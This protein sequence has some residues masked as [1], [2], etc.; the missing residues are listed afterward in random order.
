VLN[1]IAHIIGLNLR[2]FEFVLF[3]LFGTLYGVSLYCIFDKSSRDGAFLAVLSYFIIMWW[4]LDFQYVPFTLGFGFL[5]ILFM[6]DSFEDKNLATSL[7]ILIIF[8]SM[9][10]T[11]SFV[12]IFF[13]LYAF[14]KYFLLKDRKYMNIFLI[15]LITYLV[16]LIFRAEIFF[17][18]GI[19]EILGFGSY[20]FVTFGVNIVTTA[21]NPLAEFAQT[22][23]R[24][25]FIVTGLV[26]GTGFI[27]LFLKRKL[28]KISLSLLLSGSVFLIGAAA[29]PILGT[30]ALQ[31]L[32]IPLSLGVAYFQKTKFKRHFQCL[33]LIL[34]ILFVFT[35]IHSSFNSTSKQITYQTEAD[36]QSANFL[37]NYYHPNESSLMG[38]DVRTGWYIAPKVRNPN[39]NLGNSL[40]SFFVYDPDNYSCVLYTIGLEKAFLSQNYTVESAIQEM[41]EYS[42]F[43]NSGSSQIMVKRD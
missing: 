36:H 28:G 41:N 4:Y 33:F 23:S 2:C 34:I 39:V 40:Y 25:V 31:L 37:V 30:R 27:I 43:Y 15:T 21:A 14:I 11:H 35:P 26:A 13:I 22:I 19:E 17:K 32:V 18:M 8:I 29:L 42:V 3:G 20:T 38:T 5:L 12:P 24:I 1:N 7:T 6:L 10:L 9:T 16:V